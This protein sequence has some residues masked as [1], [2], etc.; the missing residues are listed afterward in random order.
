MKIRNGFVSNSSSSSFIVAY[1]GEKP[2][3]AQ[4]MESFGIAKGSPA[5]ELFGGSFKKLLAAKRVPKADIE[6]MR[7]YDSDSE[8]LKLLDGGWT[9]LRGSASDEGSGPD[10]SFLCDSDIDISTDSF[11]IIKS[12]GY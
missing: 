7:Q 9:V 2:T 12:A 3:E 1:K 11:K 6:D 5:A 8:E 10:E 4:M